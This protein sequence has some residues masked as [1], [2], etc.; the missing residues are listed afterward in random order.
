MTTFFLMLQM[1]ASGKLGV[2]PATKSVQLGRTVQSPLTFRIRF[3]ILL[4]G[5][6]RIYS[7]RRVQEIK[8]H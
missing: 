6:I 7:I 2:K 8:A 1:G 5:P 3:A 4:R